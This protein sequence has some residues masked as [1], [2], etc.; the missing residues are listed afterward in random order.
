VNR[1]R[2]LRES[3]GNIRGKEEWEKRTVK[4]GTA[5]RSSRSLFYSREVRKGRRAK[6]VSEGGGVMGGVT[7]NILGGVS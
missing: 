5:N 7:L 2:I 1:S 4:G 3:R 6:S